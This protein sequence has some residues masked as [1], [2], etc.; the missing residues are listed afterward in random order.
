MGMFKKHL[1][2]SDSANNGSY[3]SAPNPNNFLVK[4]VVEFKACF[5]SLVVYPDAKNYEGKKVLVTR[6]DPRKMKILNP[7]FEFGGVVIARFEPT[8]LGWKLAEEIG[9]KFVGPSNS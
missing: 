7:H 5:V 1:V 6:T 2:C 4:R 8:D 3:T 9:K